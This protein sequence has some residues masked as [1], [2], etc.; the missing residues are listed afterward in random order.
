[1]NTVL[2]YTHTY[3]KLYNLVLNSKNRAQKP[4]ALQ[5]LYL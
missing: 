4:N 3:A 1:M 2:G 5:V